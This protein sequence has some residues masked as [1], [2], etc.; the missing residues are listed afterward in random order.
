MLTVEGSIDF[1]KYEGL[2]PIYSEYNVSPYRRSFKI[3]SIID[4]D[5]ITAF[6]EG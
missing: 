6:A 4:Q 5:K 2:Q 3:S 1:N